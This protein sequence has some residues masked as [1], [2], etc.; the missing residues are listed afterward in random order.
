MLDVN[1]QIVILFYINNFTLIFR[2][3]SSLQEKNK[4]IL[5][6]TIIVVS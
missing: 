6:Q 2:W 5:K 1:N 4:P 3:V